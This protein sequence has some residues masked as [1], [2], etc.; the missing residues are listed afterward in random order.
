MKKLL[1][2]TY[3]NV[4]HMKGD[5]STINDKMVE[6][7]RGLAGELSFEQIQEI[8][9]LK[10]KI[11]EKIKDYDNKFH[12]VLGDLK[13]DENEKEINK[14]KISDNVTK[15]DSEKNKKKDKKGK[16]LNLLEINRR[17]IQYQE[18]KVNTS[19]FN[20]KNEEYKNDI[21]KLNEKINSL[22]SNLYG[23][24]NDELKQDSDYVNNKNFMFASKNE[25]E[26][27]KAKTDEELRNIYE[28]IEE[29]NKLYEKLFNQIKDKCTLNDLDQM[30]NLILEKTQELF[31]G[32]KNKNVD[33][34]SLQILQKNFKKLV[35]LLA[36]KEERDKWLLS[37]K[38]ISGHL[39]ASCE[40]YLGILKDDTNRHIHWK[41][42]PIKIKDNDNTDKLYKIGNGYSRL[43]SL[44]NFDING[45]PTINLI[46]SKNN[47]YIN[48]NYSN[49][50]ENNNS[51][52]NNNSLN[53]SG[54]HQSNHNNTTNNNS[55][56]DNK[57]NINIIKSR[58][59]LDKK[60]KKLPNVNLRN[61]AEHF[62]KNEKK[63]S[64]S[65]S[66]F[67]FISPRLTRTKYTN[68]KYDL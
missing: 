35:E 21:K 59:K 14:N 36:E 6:M 33:N 41:K 63:M 53:K 16:I 19:D 40:N 66:S 17:I 65:A 13:M 52:R 57:T 46:D 62:N 4:N 39:C 25:L 68:Y 48:S 54:I 29:L 30:K 34:Y 50:N 26:Q 1:E 22:L 11:N 67:N 20:L 7:N 9:E 3:E 51:K 28:K 37:K 61:S 32:M 56:E 15:I 42:L 31:V 10:D 43:L 23:I 49:V 58:N 24:N 2:K 44:I 27:Y 18:T 38:N 45:I 47:E 64:N 5:N 12:M 55:K 60:E 8:I